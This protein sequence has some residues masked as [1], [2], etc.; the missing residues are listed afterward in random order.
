MFKINFYHVLHKILINRQIIPHVIT[1]GV[2]F[3][4]VFYSVL[5][6]ML[7]DGPQVQ[8]MTVIMFLSSTQELQE[9]TVPLCI[10]HMTTAI[11]FYKNEIKKKTNNKTKT[12]HTEL[13]SCIDLQGNR[14]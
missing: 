13:K 10:I 5:E 2:G 3:Q 8:S 11:C 1:T 9:E 4:F 6:A 12:N 14:K 7:P